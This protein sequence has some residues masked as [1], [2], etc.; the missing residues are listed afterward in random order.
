MRSTLH[1]FAIFF[2]LTQPLSATKVAVVP[3]KLDKSTHEAPALFDDIVMT[4]LQQMDGIE[5]IGA[6]DINDLIGYERQQE[7]LGCD[8]DKCIS[9]LGNALGAEKLVVTKL[10]KSSQRWTIACKL[11]GIKDSKVESRATETVGS[12]DSTVVDAMPMLIG[13]LFGKTLGTLSIERTIPCSSAADCFKAGDVAY[14]HK[15]FELALVNYAKSCKY[16]S[17]RGCWAVGWH[18]QEGLGVTKNDGVARQYFISACGKGEGMGCYSYGRVYFQGIG[19]PADTTIGIKYMTLGCDQGSD[20]ACGEL[21]NAYFLATRIPRDEKKAVEL[22]RRSCKSTFPVSCFNLGF[23]YET[24][25]GLTKDLVQAK[26]YHDLAC[27][28]GYKDAC[29]RRANIP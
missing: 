17:P 2:F 25:R 13:K 11:I 6:D 23:A 15:D 24:G 12:E 8:D 3:V 28:S 16:G 26:S 4:A 10:G 27:K 19:V 14:D 9:R 29:A 20:A 7:L 21:G 18:H 22:F 1:T 5:V